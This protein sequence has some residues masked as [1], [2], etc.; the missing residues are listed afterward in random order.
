MAWYYIALHVYGAPPAAHV[1]RADEA[2]QAA[3]PGSPRGDENEAPPEGA[4]LRLLRG[5]KT[6]FRAPAECVLEWA[7][8]DTQ[9]QADDR[10]RAFR[11]RLRDAGQWRVQE[12]AA[13][14]RV[15]CRRPGEPLPSDAAGGAVLEGVRV[16]I[17]E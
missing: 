5:N 3:P 14:P 1:V 13:A 16:R 7:R 11:E 9:R 10:A 15:R 12:G 4:A 2:A 17:D 8:C 6:V